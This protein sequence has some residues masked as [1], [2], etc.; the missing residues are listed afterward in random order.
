[1]KQPSGE[2]GVPIKEYIKNK[3]EILRLV[4]SGNI[5]NN[6]AL[7]MQSG[8]NDKKE[9]MDTG[10]GIISRMIS[11]VNTVMQNGIEVNR[12]NKT[13]QTIEETQMLTTTD[14]NSMDK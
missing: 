5:G 3:R 2:N 7:N 9:E 1:M 6:N 8:Q 4:T 12:S 13:P 14:T 11:K 10:F